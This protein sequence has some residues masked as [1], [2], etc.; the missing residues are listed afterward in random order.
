M[1]R[2]KPRKN[3]KRLFQAYAKLPNRRPPLVVVGQ[4]DCGYEAALEAINDLHLQEEVR[5]LQAVS[6]E[7]LPK[8]YRNAK[9]FVHPSLAEGFGMPVSEAMTSGVPVITSNNTALVE[10]A[11]N[12]A[13]LIEPASVESIAR[14]M[15]KLLTDKRGCSELVARGPKHLTNFSWAQKAE[16]LRSSYL[17][18]LE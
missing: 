7:E 11:G 17:E 9:L 13:L 3:H 14:G 5:L 6:V 2:L 18:L 8:L 15:E 4:R 1:C 10:A 16:T 12:A